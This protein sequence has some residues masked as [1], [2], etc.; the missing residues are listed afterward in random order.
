MRRISEIERMEGLEVVNPKYP[1]TR[2]MAA[3]KFIMVEFAAEQSSEFISVYLR[4]YEAD[5]TIITAYL[6]EL[7]YLSDLGVYD[8]P[9]LLKF[10]SRSKTISELYKQGSAINNKPFISRVCDFTEDDKTPMWTIQNIIDVKLTPRLINED[11]SEFKILEKGVN[12]IIAIVS[13]FLNARNNHL[14]DLKNSNW[15]RAINPS[16]VNSVIN[17]CE[18]GGFWGTFINKIEGIKDQELREYVKENKVVILGKSYSYSIGNRIEAV[19]KENDALVLIMAEVFDST[20]SKSGYMFCIELES[21]YGQWR[22][23][24][25]LGELVEDISIMLNHVN[26]KA[27][28]EID[29]DAYKTMPEATQLWYYSNPYHEGTMLHRFIQEGDK[30]DYEV[31]DPTMQVKEPAYICSSWS[32]VNCDDPW[33]DIQSFAHIASILST[34]LSV[35]YEFQRYYPI[36]KRKSIIDIVKN[37]IKMA[38][39]PFKFVLKKTFGLS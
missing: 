20:L 26:T 17:K 21:Y 18:L 14:T 16:L 39:N 33:N 10:L 25:N 2:Y 8:K 3:Q 27:W 23:R 28:S 38:I 9:G 4:P 22:P 1:D 13:E 32:S 31:P 36:W 24:I 30:T 19:D 15:V 12:D 35:I 34:S 7:E 29:K 11:Y 37:P 6:P 5:K